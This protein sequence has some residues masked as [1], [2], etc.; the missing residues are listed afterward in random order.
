MVLPISSTGYI[1]TGFDGA[2]SGSSSEGV[3]NNT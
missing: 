2:L 1:G 3:A